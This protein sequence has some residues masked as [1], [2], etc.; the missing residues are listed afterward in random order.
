MVGA[1]LLLGGA[2]K[3][4]GGGLHDSSPL[5]L[6]QQRR[7]V[8]EGMEGLS[9]PSGRRH[10]DGGGAAATL[11]SVVGESEGCCRLKKSQTWNLMHFDLWFF[12]SRTI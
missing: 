5:A 6:R 2:V 8:V 3:V 1:L 10:A 4:E 11:W 12:E 9:R 7:E